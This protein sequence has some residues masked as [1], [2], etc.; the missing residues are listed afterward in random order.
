MRVLS[1][2]RHN[3]YVCTR[4]VH[5][6]HNTCMIRK[7]NKALGRVTKSVMK[8][9]SFLNLQILVKLKDQTFIKSLSLMELLSVEKDNRRCYAIQHIFSFRYPVSHRES[10]LRNS[11]MFT[12][13]VLL[14]RGKCSS[15][16][17]LMT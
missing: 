13:F 14:K 16:T 5:G 2:R 12:A 10:I 3:R 9:L 11:F 8:V 7:V 4:D 15:E 1:L 6:N 17:T